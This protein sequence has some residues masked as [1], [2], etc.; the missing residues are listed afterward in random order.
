MANENGYATQSL[1][2]SVTSQV[3]FFKTGGG[4]LEKKHT[5]ALE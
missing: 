3:S 5:C 4:F 1:K 2:H